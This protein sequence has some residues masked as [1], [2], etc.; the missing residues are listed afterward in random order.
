[1]AERKRQS[2]QSQ[3]IP[4]LA[5]EKNK[6]EHKKHSDNIAEKGNARLT[7]KGAKEAQSKKSASTNKRKAS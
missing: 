5:A 1:M 7:V 3:G 6:H 4:E 2:M